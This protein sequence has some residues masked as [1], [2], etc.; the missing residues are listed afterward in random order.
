MHVREPNRHATTY[1]QLTSLPH[2][3]FSALLLEIDAVGIIKGFKYMTVVERHP[4]PD[5]LLVPC[6]KVTNKAPQ[7]HPEQRA[8]GA[9]GGDGGVFGFG[10]GF[11]SASQGFPG[12][13]F[14]NSVEVG[15]GEG[16]KRW[17]ISRE[18]IPSGPSL[19]EIRPPTFDVLEEEAMVKV[20]D[21]LARKRFNLDI[22][23]IK[24]FFNDK[25]SYEC[26]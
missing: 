20:S 5:G 14:P 4:I 6:N 19:L 13:T 23:A 26:V 21:I 1:A 16:E 10:V 18:P 12:S 24:D 7:Q 25:L 15:G 11:N 17:R 2:L 3:L 9:A 8:P 22:R